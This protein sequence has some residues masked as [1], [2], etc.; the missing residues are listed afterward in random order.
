MLIVSNLVSV[1]L[2][3]HTLKS[4]NHSCEPSSLTDDDAIIST[5]F[6]ASA[7]AQ[8]EGMIPSNKRASRTPMRTPTSATPRDNTPAPPDTAVSLTLW[9]IGGGGGG[10]GV[11]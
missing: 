4:H 5:G 3:N 7:A 9:C 1:L 2:N 11:S 10:G 8:D 6:T